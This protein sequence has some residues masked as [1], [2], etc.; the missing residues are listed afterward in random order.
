M[1][2]FQV[3]L[4]SAILSKE[5]LLIKNRPTKTA[6][7]SRKNQKWAKKTQKIGKNHSFFTKTKLISTKKKDNQNY[8]NNYYRSQ[9][10]PKARKIN[11][12]LNLKV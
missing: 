12:K 2:S 1:Y 3:S 5:K 4:H 7:R 10:Y 8:Q 9:N 11:L 6:A